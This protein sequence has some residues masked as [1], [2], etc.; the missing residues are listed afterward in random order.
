MLFTYVVEHKYSKLI[1]YLI[2]Y[3]LLKWMTKIKDDDNNLHVPALLGFFNVSCDILIH[4]YQC[5]LHNKNITNWKHWNF[6]I[7]TFSV[8]EFY[9][10]IPTVIINKILN[11]FVIK[12]DKTFKKNVSNTNFTVHY[13][14]YSLYVIMYAWI[15][16]FRNFVSSYGEIRI[17]RHITIIDFVHMW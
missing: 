10:T 3:S 2:N 1:Y 11:E 6:E 17:V 9:Q 5:Y 16:T 7:T 15:P 14:L 13:I 12:V 8:R 4:R